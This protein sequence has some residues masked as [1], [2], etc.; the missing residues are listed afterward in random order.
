MKKINLDFL[1][2][3][4]EIRDFEKI[5]KTNLS[6]YSNFHERS[7]R[8]WLDTGRWLN[9]LNKRE[10][11][12]NTVLGDVQ[13]HL[14][15]GY[16]KL[17][18][19]YIEKG[20]TVT[21]ILGTTLGLYRDNKL[22]EHDDDL[23]LGID[24]FD[25]DKI[26]KTLWIRS[27]CKG[28]KMKV[29][30]WPTKLDNN[31]GNG[32][33]KLFKI[34][35]NKYVIGKYRF[36]NTVSIDL[37]PITRTID[38]PDIRD[39]YLLNL[40]NIYKKNNSPFFAINRVKRFVNIMTDDEI[41]LFFKEQSLDSSIDFIKEFIKKTKNSKNDLYI[42]LEKDMGKMNNF[43]IGEK[44]SFGNVYIVM[45]DI[46]DEYLTK[47]YGNWREPVLSHIHFVDSK[48]IKKIK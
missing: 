1:L 18:F 48:R 16:S 31:Y 6:N 2:T 37:W 21:S 25:F 17:I 47:Q 42:P 30:S 4:N 12:I 35:K 34:R 20:A 46:D 32:V 7:W 3:E 22:I 11:F 45:P 26:K 13:N 33:A 27:I 15:K 44:K 38:S 40:H 5:I 9:K 24:I 39:L 41:D 14:Q 23:D 29:Y 43:K 19:P 36:T 8:L 28:W 10:E